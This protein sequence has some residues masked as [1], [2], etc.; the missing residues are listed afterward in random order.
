MEKNKT[1]QSWVIP[2]TAILVAII[3]GSSIFASQYYKQ[4]S[5]ERQHQADTKLQQ[6][7]L[8]VEACIERNKIKA[9]QAQSG[10]SFIGK[11]YVSE[12]CE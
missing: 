9:E 1:R 3:I 10:D 8:R 4:R 12:K 11:F 2:V 6:D 5:E 7:R